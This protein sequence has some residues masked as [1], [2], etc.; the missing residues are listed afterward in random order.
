MV[1]LLQLD[2]LKSSKLYHFFVRSVNSS[3]KK[4]CSCLLKLN[5]TVEQKI[6]ISHT[7]KNHITD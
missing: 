7:A 3:D 6:S 1:D 2:I 4:C 5:H